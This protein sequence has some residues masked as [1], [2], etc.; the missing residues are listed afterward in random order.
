[1]LPIQNTKSIV[2]FLKMK[3]TLR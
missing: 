2:L 1:M 3:R